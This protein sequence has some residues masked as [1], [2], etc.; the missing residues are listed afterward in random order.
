MLIHQ[1]RFR[2][3]PVIKHFT[4]LPNISEFSATFTFVKSKQ[5]IRDLFLLGLAVISLG[6]CVNQSE[7]QAKKSGIDIYFEKTTHNYGD[8]LVDSDGTYNFEFKNI[9]EEP[10]I[11]NKVRSSCGCTV[12]SWPREPIE[13]G[14]G[15]QIAVKY[16]TAVA[17]S[18]MKTVTVYSSAANSPVKLIVKGKVLANKSNISTEDE[19]TD[20]TDF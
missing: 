18:F 10:I 14:S 8:I 19:N 5:T 3:F 9:G 16:N 2:H 17:G 15:G 1:Y 12:P 4:S 7:Q 20:T 11:V 6:S 13:S